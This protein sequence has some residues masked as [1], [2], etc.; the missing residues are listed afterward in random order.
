MIKY[1]NVWLLTLLTLFLFG[2]SGEMTVTQSADDNDNSAEVEELGSS[3]TKQIIPTNAATA[4]PTIADTAV[5]T[6]MAEAPSP[7]A[8]KTPIGTTP[9]SSEAAPPR[10]E[11]SSDTFLIRSL[12]TD[13]NIPFEELAVSRS[14]QHLAEKLQLSADEITMAS[15]DQTEMSNAN[16][17][18]GVTTKSGEIESHGIS[19]GYEIILSVDTQTYRYRILHNLGHYCPG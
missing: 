10:L 3:A 7:Q 8:V 9:T 13:A 5:P 18:Q 6:N 12:N 2:C 15:V 17:C 19:I 16:V 4:V 11:D 14:K 1:G